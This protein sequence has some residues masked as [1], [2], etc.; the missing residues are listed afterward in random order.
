M[1]EP[2][3]EKGEPRTE[4][5]GRGELGHGDLRFG[6]KPRLLGGSSCGVV[7]A[8]KTR[9]RL[10]IGRVLGVICRPP[11]QPASPGGHQSDPPESRA[12]LVHPG[13]YLRRP[14]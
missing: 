14:F 7:G 12:G 9:V 3:P 10:S 6:E 4:G 1:R 5:G 11:H 8:T 2:E 13:E